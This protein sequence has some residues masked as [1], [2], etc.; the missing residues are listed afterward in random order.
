MVRVEIGGTGR[1]AGGTK[2]RMRVSFIVDG[3]QLIDCGVRVTLRSRERDVAQ[4]F[5]NRA[6]IGAVSQQMRGEC[7]TE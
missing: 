3:H 7:M 1:D 4:E 2:L 5:L 6:E